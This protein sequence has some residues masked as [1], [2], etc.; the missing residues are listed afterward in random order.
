MASRNRRSASGSASTTGRLG[1][2]ARASAK[3][4]PILSPSRAAPSVRAG[5]HCADLID[6]TTTKASTGPARRRWI[7]SVES[8]RSHTDRY[9]RL[10]STLMMIPLDD[11]TAGRAASVLAKR[12]LEA[13]A[14]DPAIGVGLAQRRSDLP[15]GRGRARHQCGAVANEQA[16]ARTLC[17]DAF[18][19]SEREASRRGQIGH[20]A[21]GGQLGDNAGERTAAQR[22]LHRP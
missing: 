21:V 9:R 13:A 16:E 6:A 3:P 2:M 12:K 8:R 14:P 11:P 22:L 7:R 4:M 19:R 10:E 5:M 18:A 17:A 15:A 20:C 1:Y